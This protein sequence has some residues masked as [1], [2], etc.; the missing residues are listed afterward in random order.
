MARSSATP[1]RLAPHIRAVVEKVA[2]MRGQS[3]SSFME[4]AAHDAA[5]S[6]LDKQ[7]SREILHALGDKVS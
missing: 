6:Y 1:V 3:L 4:L 5:L 2:Q 7:K